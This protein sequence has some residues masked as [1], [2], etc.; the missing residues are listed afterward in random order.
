MLVG[1]LADDCGGI[2]EA[3]G[4]GGFS[5]VAGI[6]RVF[7]LR[8]YTDRLRMWRRSSTYRKTMGDFSRNKK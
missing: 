1:M 8:E 2:L 4:Y 6:F 7:S 5:W 3:L